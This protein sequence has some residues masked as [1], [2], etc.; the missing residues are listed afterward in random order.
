MAVMTEAEIALAYQRGAIPQG[1]YESHE[2]LRRRLDLMR[3]AIDRYNVELPKMIA[4]VNQ[5]ADSARCLG[6]RKLDGR[7]RT[8]LEYNQQNAG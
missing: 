6:R 1:V 8:R 5:Q 2:E 4:E 3:A 7:P